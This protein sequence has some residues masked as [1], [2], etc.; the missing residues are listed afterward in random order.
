MASIA[1]MDTPAMPSMP[2]TKPR[3]TAIVAGIRVLQTN[4][5][6]VV[7]AAALPLWLPVIWAPV[8]RISTAISVK[9]PS[10]NKA[11]VKP[12]I[13][14][15]SG[16]KVFMST[17]SISGISIM[18]AGTFWRKANAGIRD[19]LVLNCICVINL[20]FHTPLYLSVAGLSPYNWYVHY[21]CCTSPVKHELQQQRA[22]MCRKRQ[23][24]QRECAA[25][26]G[27]APGADA[28][29]KPGGG[30]PPSCPDPGHPAPADP[31]TPP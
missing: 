10:L 20:T 13:F 5:T 28:P 11:V 15:A 26:C 30:A 31:G 23:R 18:P 9:A 21:L 4:T 24:S 19:G 8:A 12:P 25:S 17:P 2:T 16:A 22:M 14:K 27:G 7:E 3:I 6:V 29:C 1:R